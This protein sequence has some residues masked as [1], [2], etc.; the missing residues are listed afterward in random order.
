[1]TT[2]LQGAAEQAARTHQEPESPRGL[3]AGGLVPASVDVD[4]R[5]ARNFPT[6]GLGVQP[7]VLVTH[8]QEGAPAAS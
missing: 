1:V 7:E 2:R 4:V 3:A 8:S 5:T 6:L